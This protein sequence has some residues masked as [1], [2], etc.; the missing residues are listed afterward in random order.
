LRFFREA[1]L[2]TD[3]VKTF[4]NLCPEVERWLA[5]TQAP[6]ERADG[7]RKLLKEDRQHDL[8]GTRPFQDATGRLYFHARTAILTGRRFR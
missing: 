6:P 4:D 7:V 8:S 2:E 5:T 3:G 1:G